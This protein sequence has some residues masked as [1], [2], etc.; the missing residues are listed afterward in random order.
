[1]YISTHER[2]HALTHSHTHAQ[3]HT[4]TYTDRQTDTHTH[5][6]TRTHTDI[7]TETILRNQACAWF[8][9]TVACGKHYTD[10]D[11]LHFSKKFMNCSF[12]QEGYR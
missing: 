9:N 4:H 1:M 10:C 6:H 2:T 8:N 12:M 3:T 11:I 7:H 5:E